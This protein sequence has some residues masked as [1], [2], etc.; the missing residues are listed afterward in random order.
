MNSLSASQYALINQLDTK[1]KAYVGGFGS[2]KTFIGCI[3]LLKFALEHPGRVSGYF[4]P[5]YTSIEDVFYPTL[6][7]AAHLMGMTVDVTLSKKEAHLYR[8]RKYYG[9]V[10][11]RSMDKPSTIVGFKVAR[12]LVDEVDTMPTNK[13]TRSWTNIL[14]RMRQK[15][16]IRNDV[17]VTTTPEGFGFVYEKFA[18]NPKSMYSMVQASTYENER[19][20]PDDYI[21]SLKQTYPPNLIEAYINGEFTNLTSGSV[22]PMFD[23]KL[24]HS[25]RVLQDGEPIHIGMDFNVNNMSAIIHIVDEDDNPIAVDEIGG[26]RDTPTIIETIRD[27]YWGPNGVETRTITIYPD[28][29]GKNTSSK[30][31]SESDI[32]MLQEAGFYVVY[33]STN[34]RVRDRV[35]GMN[36]MFC[37]IDGVRRYKVNTRTCPGYTKDLEQQVYNDAGEPCKS[38]GNDHKPDAGGY[39]ISYE[40]PIIK[41]I[42]QGSYAWQ[43]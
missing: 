13:A 31:A 21:A 36:A 7:E 23:R 16:D 18:D 20:L 10:K 38:K 35:N 8:G 39:F 33:S 3:D 27:R 14:A 30:N 32:A 43:M 29:S 19:Y 1:F 12:A 22:Y 6:E 4:G 41:P 40:Y 2:G 9:L 37:N 28:S 17:I 5:S 34:P 42:A 11:C 24:N 15:S 25:D 26:S